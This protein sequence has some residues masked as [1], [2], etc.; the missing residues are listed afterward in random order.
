MLFASSL[1]LIAASCK[2]NETKEP[3]K[4]PE[5]DTP[6]APPTDP[7]KTDPNQNG[8]AKVIKTD[9]S[10]LKLQ[11]NLTNNTTKKEILEL[12]KK[13]DKL[14]NLTES[15]FDF[16]LEKKSLLN[17]KGEISITSKSKSKLISGTLLLTIDHLQEV[18]PRKH[19]YS[20]DKTEV[21]EIGYNKYGQ[22][23]QFDRNVKKVP[24]VLPE[25][26][27]S[28]SRAFEKNENQTVENIDKWDTSN[29]EDMSLMFFGAKNFNTD[30]SNWK[31]DK[32]KNMSYM[33]YAT[34]KFNINLDKW[35]TT[36]VKNMNR[37]FQEAEA[38]NGDISTWDTKNVSDMAYMFSG[39]T[40]FNKDISGWN[41][42]N[43]STM[44]R[45]FENASKFN[46][47]IFKLVSPKVKNMQYMFYNAKEFNNSNISN[48]N[49][50]SVTDIRSMFR[51]AT[52]FN[53]N[54][55]WQTENITNMSSLFTE[56][57]SFNGDITKWKTGNVVDMSEMF[58]KA[59]AFNKDIFSW[60]IKK[61][62]DVRA[63]FFFAIN[64]DHSLKKWVFEQGTASNNFANG[65]KLI[66]SP[67][68]LPI[69]KPA[70]TK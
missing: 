25:E 39:A 5:M 31:T 49:T 11:T 48:W 46:S 12:L 20:A 62:K 69:F 70:K 40:T 16:K 53:Q 38:F 26:V 27:I 58:W 54:L 42:D 24:K 32:V 29:I 33:F 4:E 15:D 47:P 19:K 13:Q 2:N 44:E 55:N 18:T 65:T 63:M 61:V 57:S 64:F 10:K 60:N 7:E 37:M 3:K 43:V 35:N 21:L 28:L 68:K 22:I 30:I 14:G 56:A 1:P 8:E 17:R 41:V 6:I 34:K 36:S 51:G 52:K 59:S 66:R 45:M 67:D 23:E 9:I 50:S